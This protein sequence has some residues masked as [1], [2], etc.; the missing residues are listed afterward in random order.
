MLLLPRDW[1]PC[2]VCAKRDDAAVVVCLSVC[3]L[4]VWWSMHVGIRHLWRL[5]C[6]GFCIIERFRT[7][8]R[9]NVFSSAPPSSPQL[10]SAVFSHPSKY[11]NA[12]AV[13]SPHRPLVFL[14]ATQT[15]VVMT[16]QTHTVLDS[17]SRSDSTSGMSVHYFNDVIAAMARY[18]R[19]C[20]PFA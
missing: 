7:M 17:S 14:A 6:Y 1:S 5:S 2:C 4:D 13:S 9:L 12:A 11:D 15:L 20:L 8:L 16:M 19:W 3:L 10:F 18:S